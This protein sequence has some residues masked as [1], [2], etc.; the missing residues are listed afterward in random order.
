MW[1][2]YGMAEPVLNSTSG[3]QWAAADFVWLTSFGWQLTINHSLKLETLICRFLV[4]YGATLS[5]SWQVS[6]TRAQA[7]LLIFCFH[8]GIKHHLS[9][10]TVGTNTACNLTSMMC[11]LSTYGL[12]CIFSV[13]SLCSPVS[14]LWWRHVCYYEEHG[15]WCGNTICYMKGIY[16]N[17]W[18]L[19]NIESRRGERRDVGRKNG[20]RS[21]K[22]TG[23]R[24]EVNGGEMMK[25]K[26]E[27]CPLQ[28][29][30]G[31]VLPLCYLNLVTS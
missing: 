5:H 7:T 1:S 6:V 12:Q 17:H 28:H 29:I 11:P 26:R 21:R 2:H 9:H 24:N 25:V 18:L 16:A 8:R 14:S 10:I 19:H 23:E 30:W 22:V 15:P 13:K 3:N 4:K 27:L 20:K 31:N